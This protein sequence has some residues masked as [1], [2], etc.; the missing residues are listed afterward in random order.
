MV[1]E[2]Q[3]G[4]ISEFRLHAKLLMRQNF[5]EIS[6][7]LKKWSKDGIAKISHFRDVKAMYS[8]YYLYRHWDNRPSQ[9]EINY[10]L[11]SIES[12]A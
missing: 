5:L 1:N 6:E 2:W 9:Y 10:S 7:V 3:Y 4:D 11:E 8:E 12:K